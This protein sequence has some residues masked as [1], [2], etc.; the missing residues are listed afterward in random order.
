[1]ARR[2]AATA[3]LP[4]EHARAAA[5]GDGAVPL[6][7]GAAAARSRVVPLAMGRRVIQTPLGMLYMGDH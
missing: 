2:G 6:V 7:R 1:M 3:E 5:G 4:R